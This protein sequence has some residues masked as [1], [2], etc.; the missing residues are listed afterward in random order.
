MSCELFDLLDPPLLEIVLHVEMTPREV[1]AF[2]DVVIIGN[3]TNHKVV[4]PVASPSMAVQSV[5][6]EKDALSAYIITILFPP[7]SATTWTDYSAKINFWLPARQIFFTI[8]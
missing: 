5:I 2:L 7:I 6:Y 4:P 8:T 3:Q 1:N